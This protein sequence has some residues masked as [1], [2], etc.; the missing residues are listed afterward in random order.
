MF[1]PARTPKKLINKLYKDI[2]KAMGSAYIRRRPTSLCIEP[3]TSTPDQL[4]MSVLRKAL[5]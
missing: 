3:T 1:T 2:V 4:A 5:K